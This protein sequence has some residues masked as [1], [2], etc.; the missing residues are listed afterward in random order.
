MG[1]MGAGGVR[2]SISPRCF[3]HRGPF[4]CTSHPVYW[5]VLIRANDRMRDLAGITALRVCF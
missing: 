5:R 2:R 1:D 3:T 4:I